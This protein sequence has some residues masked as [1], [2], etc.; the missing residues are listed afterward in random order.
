MSTGVL[1][2]RLIVVWV[3][4]LAL[5]GVIV[6]IELR[7][8]PADPSFEEAASR[9]RMLLPVAVEQLGAIELA[10]AGT[11]HRFE[12]DEAGNWFY[13]GM[14][15]G[16]EAVHGHQADP[17]MAV[18][19]EQALAVLGRARIERQMEVGARGNEYGLASPQL[20][21]LAY[22]PKEALPLVQYVVGDIAPDQLSRYLQAAG[23][24]AVI[25]VA[26]YQIDNLL[27]LIQAV[28]SMP[29]SPAQG[30]TQ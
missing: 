4:L 18:R 24:P 9:E 27:S 10:Y 7:D 26:N 29:V 1:R 2:P 8:R 15:S 21:I 30:K 6:T 20:L 12:R 17:A 23:S 3:V 14:H 28:T 11:L 16:K 5:A 13:H 25:T 22:R 19:I